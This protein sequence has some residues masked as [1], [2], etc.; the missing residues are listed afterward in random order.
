[1]CECGCGAPAQAG[2]RF[3]RGHAQRLETPNSVWC[4]K[5]QQFQSPSKFYQLDRP[6]WCKTCHGE[7]RRIEY[8]DKTEV[9]KARSSRASKRCNAK[10]RSNALAAYGN[11]CACCGES[12]WEF[13]AIDHIDGGGGKHRRSL[14][15]MGG[16]G[17]PFY[18][19]L[20]RQGFPSGFR[21][22][23]HNCNAASA[24]YGKCPHE[25]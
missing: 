23:C 8:R 4:P 24:L 13:L 18:R 7:A 22:L 11:C 12:T 20:E 16:G 3:V 14:G 15:I 1:M 5:C 9:V 25:G 2:K 17:A 10:L 6:D 19:W 21:V